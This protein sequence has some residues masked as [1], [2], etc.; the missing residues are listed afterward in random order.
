MQIKEIKKYIDSNG[1]EKLYKK[2]EA[3][4]TIVDEWNEKFVV[5]DLL[6]EQELSYA[7]QQL[8]G[9]YGMFSIIGEAINSYKVNE[10][11]A[12]I[13]KAFRDAEKKPNVSQIKESARA[14]TKELR[15]Y[16]SDFLNYAQSAE[17]SIGSVQSRLKRLTTEKGA[18]GIDF[19]GEI[20]NA[21]KAKEEKNITWGK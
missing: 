21:E 16:R 17:K 5:G 12:F 18:R 13:E 19:T 9:I 11:L 20:K 3:K 4:F 15:E 2:F 1:I 8:T 14:S 7:L 6:N 10:E